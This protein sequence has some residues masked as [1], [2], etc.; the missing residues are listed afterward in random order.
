MSNTG[1]KRNV[2]SQ[3][4]QKKKR[5]VSNGLWTQL[6]QNDPGMFYISEL[7]IPYHTFV[8]TDTVKWYGEVREGMHLPV[9]PV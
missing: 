7:F 8:M 2:N 4:R 5:S 9:K 3:K 6:G 1:N